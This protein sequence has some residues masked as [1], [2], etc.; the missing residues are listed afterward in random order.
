MLGQ[1]MDFSLSFVPSVYAGSPKGGS[2][3][4]FLEYVEVAPQ[5]GYLVTLLSRK[6]YAAEGITLRL[7]VDAL[8]IHDLEG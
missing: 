7:S 4:E 6:A 1:L 2:I 3:G 5:V 8:I